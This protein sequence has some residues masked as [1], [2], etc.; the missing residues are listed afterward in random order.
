MD[1]APQLTIEQAGELLRS[2]GYP[3][4]TG[5]L[6][7]LCRPSIDKGPPSCGRWGG[8]KLFKT[9]AVLAWA[10]KRFVKVEAA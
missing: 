5:H 3:I 2:R 8:V 6:S 9:E 7:F 4:K 1:T 10:E